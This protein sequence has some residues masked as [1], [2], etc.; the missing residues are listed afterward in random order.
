[1]S[2]AYNPSI[3]TKDLVLNF[4]ASNYHKSYPTENQLITSG[5]AVRTINSSSPTS[6]GNYDSFHTTGWN[7]TNGQIPRYSYVGLTYDVILNNALHSTGNQ[8]L[9]GTIPAAHFGPGDIVN[10]ALPISFEQKRHVKIFSADGGVYIPN[11]AERTRAYF[12]TDL[13]ISSGAI[14]ITNTKLYYANRIY[15][16]LNSSS[17][18]NF[19]NGILYSTSNNGNLIFDGTNTFAYTN[20][21][22]LPSSNSSSI[23]LEAVAKKTGS[24]TWMTV[25]GTNGSFTQIGFNGGYF[26][27]GRN[28]GNGNSFITTGSTPI[29]NN[30]WYHMALTYNGNY[31][32]AYLNG[33]E[34]ARGNIGS[35]GG[36]NGVSVL[37]SYRADGA[38]EVLNGRVA[39]AR[40]YGTCLSTPQIK[41]NFNAIRKRFGI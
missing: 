5:S 9:T 32:I 35:N 12:L 10:S 33:E 6:G 36:A 26:A 2:T 1:M 14:K 25:L 17:Y 4:D 7:L 24:G 38:W 28:G 23:T 16:T 20:S 27:A 3:V 15:N 31:A 11:N 13:L 21:V 29:T 19:Q 22:L 30:V 40:A 34:V 39:I 37:G 8:I 41:Q 18:A